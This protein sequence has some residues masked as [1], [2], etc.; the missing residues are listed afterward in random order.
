MQ[1]A[2]RWLVALAASLIG[3]VV[4]WWVADYGRLDT[5]SAIGVATFVASLI[6]TPLGLP[7]SSRTAD[8]GSR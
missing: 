3:F 1:H 2:S 8:S 6:G 4:A 7:L 5:Q